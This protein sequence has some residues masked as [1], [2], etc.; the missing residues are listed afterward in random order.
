MSNQGHI[1]S[2]KHK[3]F[4]H[5]VKNL[6]GPQQGRD[7]STKGK[8]FIETCIS[9]F[10]IWFL[11]NCVALLFVHSKI[12]PVCSSSKTESKS[13]GCLCGSEAQRAWEADQKISIWTVWWALTSSFIGFQHVSALKPLTNS[14]G[15]QNAKLQSCFGEIPSVQRCSEYWKFLT[16]FRSQV[17]SLSQYRVKAVATGDM[18]TLTIAQHYHSWIQVPW[19]TKNWQTE[20]KL[21]S[22]SI[23]LDLPA[24]CN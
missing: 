12:R 9:N 4:T 17:V 6:L 23:K 7:G 5:F 16:E 15:V 14:I 3:S 22:D 21:S 1:L 18:H 11:E 20:G 19:L 13:F 8:K 2:L 10:V 24:T